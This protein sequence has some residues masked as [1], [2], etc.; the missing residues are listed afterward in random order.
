MRVFCLCGVMAVLIILSPAIGLGE[1]G[2]A[3]IG[4][5][6]LGV[7]YFVIGGGTLTGGSSGAATTLGGGGHSVA[8]SGL[9]LGGEGHSVFSD[10][11]AGGL[12]FFDIG[13][14]AVRRGNLIVYP[15]LGL[16]GGSLARDSDDTV[17]QVL[18]IDGS[19]GP[20]T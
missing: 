19:V 7:G 6:E 1:P 17:S 16:G 3:R 5:H 11:G 12:G 18:L 20:T 8:V 4:N 9:I 13:Y 2:E 14:A 10:E 15:L